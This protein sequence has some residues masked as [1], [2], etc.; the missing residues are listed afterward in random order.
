MRERLDVRGRLDA[1][2][3]LEALD[4]FSG[5]DPEAGSLE[6]VSESSLMVG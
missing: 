4:V 3:R 2:G 6:R 5:Q 1:S